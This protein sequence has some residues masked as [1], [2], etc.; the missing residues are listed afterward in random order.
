MSFLNFYF[1]YLIQTLYVSRFEVIHLFTFVHSVPCVYCCFE[2]SS[3][4]LTVILRLTTESFTVKLLVVKRKI[5]CY[6]GEG[7]TPSQTLFLST[8]FKA[9]RRF[10][11]VSKGSY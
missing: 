9:H 6:A 8:V 3:L 4:I 2:N 11:T 7:Q 10:I 5:L 1:R